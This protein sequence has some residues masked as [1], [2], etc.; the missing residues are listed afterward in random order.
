MLLASEIVHINLRI[1][2]Y[3]K[4]RAQVENPSATLPS[5]QDGRAELG[6]SQGRKLIFIAC[7]RRAE[8][9]SKTIRSGDTV[10]VRFVDS[11][12]KLLSN[13]V[14]ISISWI[15]LEDRVGGINM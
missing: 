2:L 11:A 9:G 6:S 3:L 4:L 15:A 14:R 12:R 7:I 13:N 1:K 10:K 8:G 5:C